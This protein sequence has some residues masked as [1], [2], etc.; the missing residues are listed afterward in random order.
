M[1][2]IKVSDSPY[3]S[4]VVVVNKKG[5]ELRFCVDYRDLNFITISNKFPLPRTDILLYGLADAKFYIT[6]DFK[7]GFWQIKIK[8]GHGTYIAFITK[9]GLF[10]WTRMPFGLKTAPSWF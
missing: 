9:D 1:G 6:L 8:T 2:I 4:A 5:G 3:A 10:E 7:S